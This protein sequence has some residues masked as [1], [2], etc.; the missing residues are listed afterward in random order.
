LA[1]QITDHQTTGVNLLLW[2]AAIH[3]QLP[4]PGSNLLF[5]PADPLHEE[6]VEIGTHHGK[7]EHPLQE[8]H[9][10][11]LPLAQRPPVECEPGQLPV[12]IPTG[13]IKI[14]GNGSSGLVLVESSRLMGVH[15]A[16]GGRGGLISM[17]FFCTPEL[18]VFG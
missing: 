18:F 14:S 9:A 13:G 11:V 12:E 10:T 7:K 17:T 16:S 8:R 1:Q 3:R 5:E 4:H 15:G 2:Q 6:F